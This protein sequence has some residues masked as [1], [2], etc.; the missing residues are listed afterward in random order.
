MLLTVA[1]PIQFTAVWTYQTRV[2]F[3]WAE[4]DATAEGFE[5]RYEVA[6]SNSWSPEYYLNPEDPNL[7]LLPSGDSF[8]IATSNSGGFD[9]GAASLRSAAIGGVDSNGNSL[10]GINSDYSYTFQIQAV[11]ATGVSSPTSFTLPAASNLPVEPMAYDS[12]TGTQNMLSV[13]GGYDTSE[14]FS[15]SEYD[16]DTGYDNNGNILIY[17]NVW[18]QRI[19][20]SLASG[21]AG[22][23]TM[24]PVDHGSF[25]DMSGTLGSAADTPATYELP[26]YADTT[27]DPTHEYTYLIAQQN[28]V[29]VLPSEW[30]SINVY[31]QEGVY[32]TYLPNLD[33]RNLHGDPLSAYPTVYDGESAIHVAWTDYIDNPAD[34]NGYLLEWSTSASGPFTP[35]D[36]SDF[37]PTDT[38]ASPQVG[39]PGIVAAPNLDGTFYGSSLNSTY[40]FEV[41]AV[42]GQASSASDTSREI[43]S[44]Y[45]ESTS[46]T[47]GAA[48]PAGSPTLN[49]IDDTQSTTDSV[50]LSWSFP[51]T[52]SWGSIPSADQYIVVEMSTDGGGFVQ[53]YKQAESLGNAAT[54]GGLSPGTDYTFRIRAAS[55]NNG[56]SA[57]DSESAASNTEESGTV[58]DAAEIAPVDVYPESPTELQIVWCRVDNPDIVY[59]IQRESLSDPAGW[60]PV[61]YSP[62]GNP[63]DE[64]IYWPA[65]AELYDGQQ[66]PENIDPY[67]VDDNGVAEDT[68]YEYRIRVDNTLDRQNIN[69]DPNQGGSDLDWNMS[70]PGVATS[71]GYTPPAAPSNLVMTENG[72]GTIT[73]KWTNNSTHAP[74]IEIEYTNAVLAPDTSDLNSAGYPELGTDDDIRGGSSYAFVVRTSLS[75]NNDSDTFTPPAGSNLTFRVLAYDPNSDYASDYTN[76]VS[77]AVPATPTHVIAMAISPTSIDVVWDFEMDA[78]N[79]SQSGSLNAQDN[80]GYRLLNENGTLISWESTD[81]HQEGSAIAPADATDWVVDGLDPTETYTFTVLPFTLLPTDADDPY[82][83]VGYA[84]G[85]P[86]ETNVSQDVQPLQPGMEDSYKL[87]EPYYPESVISS[88]QQF[89][90]AIGINPGHSSWLQFGSSAYESAAGNALL[91]G[92]NVTFTSDDYDDVGQDQP[93]QTAGGWRQMPQYTAP[94]PDIYADT[95]PGS[96]LYSY[97]YITFLEDTEQQITE[98]GGT[99]ST[100]SNGDTTLRWSVE[101]K[102]TVSIIDEGFSGGVDRFEIMRSGDNS[103]ALRVTYNFAGSLVGDIETAVSGVV[104]IPMGSS[105]VTLAVDVSSTDG[106]LAMELT[107]G[108]EGAAVPGSPYVVGS[109]VVPVTGD[110][111]IKRAAAGS[112]EIDVFQGSGSSEVLI[113]SEDANLPYSLWFSGETTSNTVTLDL[114]NGDLTNGND[115]SVN[116]ATISPGTLTIIGT[117]S[118]DQMSLASEMVS[119]DNLDVNLLA[120][121]NDTI[122]GTGGSE[123]LNVGLG[124]LQLANEMDSD[125]TQ[126]TVIATDTTIAMSAS[127]VYLASLQLNGTATCTINHIGGVLVGPG[128]PSNVAK[129]LTLGMLSM[130]ADAK[131]DLMDNEMVLDAADGSSIVE[132]L[133]KE[134]YDDGKW[135]LNGIT[136]SDA[137]DAKLENTTGNG[138][139]GI[140]LGYGN[141]EETTNTE[142]RLTWMGDANLDGTVT[143][144]DVTAYIEGNGSTWSTGD[145]NYD[146]VKN[147]DDFSLFEFGSAS[148]TS[149]G[150]VTNSNV[151]NA[152]SEV[153]TFA[154]MALT[155]SQFNSQFSGAYYYNAD[156]NFNGSVDNSDLQEFQTV[157]NATPANYAISGPNYEFVV[158]DVSGFTY[159]WNSNVPWAVSFGNVNDSGSEENVNFWVSGTYSLSLTLT[160]ANGLSLTIPIN[161]VVYITQQDTSFNDALG[162]NVTAMDGPA[163]LE[164]MATDSE[165]RIVAVGQVNVGGIAGESCWLIARYNADGTLDT[166]FGDGQGWVA[167]NVM[168][169]GWGGDLIQATSINF[170]IIDGQQDILVGGD[171]AWHGAVIRLNPDGSMDTSFAPGMDDAATVPGVANIDPIGQLNSMTIDSEGRIVFGGSS[172]PN[173]MIGRLNSDG[174]LDTSFGDENDIQNG[175]LL[176]SGTDMLWYRS[177]VTDWS[178]QVMMEINPSTGLETGNMLTAGTNNGTFELMR[179][180]SN[181]LLDTSFG[182]N[183]FAPWP[184]GWGTTFTATSAVQMNNGNIVV[185][186][187]DGNGDFVIV[188]YTPDGQ[189]NTSFGADGMTTVSMGGNAQQIAVDPEGRLVII[190]YVYSNSVFQD[191]DALVRLNADGSLD[192][193]FGKDGNGIFIL[194]VEDGGG[195]DDFGQAVIFQNGEIVVGSTT[196]NMFGL[197]EISGP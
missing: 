103:G 11:S 106:T 160:S 186:G 37:V 175:V 62:D 60:Q 143:A 27:M 17:S 115:D 126:W 59:E 71:S 172:Y 112:N 171:T 42:A 97:D 187:N 74:D 98:N 183:G 9:T 163:H 179:F 135:D 134:A 45:I 189:I 192:Q 5:I 21:T 119:V 15:S 128:Q 4:N 80:D 166:T 180:M 16:L 41:Q 139:Y 105:E 32:Y 83:V 123:T 116:F 26:A 52:F 169:G 173:T 82:G 54:I 7:T 33:A 108:A 29:P 131:I 170:Q 84:A 46:V 49:T 64:T 147:S 127:S 141:Y 57:I 93:W 142:V 36:S 177:G 159:S 66:L 87:G 197:V 193:T 110:I 148:Y 20:D 137:V 2:D 43:T 67:Y 190:G 104:I 109:N 153:T 48:V 164:A 145:F 50:S 6:G 30:Q 81:G 79:F 149:F 44:S 152:T 132:G 95:A 162:F 39:I 174:T 124:T 196:N 3:T 78:I 90:D 56:G 122:A 138:G 51:D 68:E 38:S 121:P 125:S 101:E 34:A 58:P 130:G 89:V 102:P 151:Q 31:P 136:S 195:S 40:Y 99:L 120:I 165:G 91:T 22:Y 176:D 75:S 1:A 65:S 72:D 181:G 191:D 184:S 155:E 88:M 107:G 8:G 12:S 150:N 113:A 23:D 194:D 114:S 61:Y 92:A 63:S 178:V 133:L 96:V 168:D 156:L 118:S 146:G 182:N 140:T 24:L 111:T 77:T 10:F 53:Q 70:A 25:G 154:A 188:C 76:V 18:V 85:N 28:G 73:L 69:T 167:I 14:A 13:S 35:V 129:L 161:A 100:E 157:V 55:S 117:T 86:Q 158:P 19:D 47:L 185:A 144:A 94:G